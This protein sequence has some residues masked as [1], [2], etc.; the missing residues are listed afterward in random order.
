[1]EVYVFR[2]GVTKREHIEA[3][4][5]HLNSVEGLYKWNFDLNDRE[6]ILRAEAINISPGKIAEVLKNADYFCDELED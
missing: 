6:N 5:P 4:T 2:T 3:L 1:M